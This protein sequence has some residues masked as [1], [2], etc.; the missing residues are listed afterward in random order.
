MTAVSHSEAR[1]EARVTFPDGAVYSA[2][3]GT[4]LLHYVNAAYPNGHPNRPILGGIIDNNLAELTYSVNRDLTLQPITLRDSD[5]GR[6]YRR[7]LVF[8]LITAAA[9]CFPGVKIAV[10]HSIPTGGF[11]CEPLN[12]PNFTA[13][14]LDRIRA[15]M[16]AIVAADEPFERKTIP[17]AEAVAWFTEHGD[18]DMVRL[19]RTRDKDYLTVYTMRGQVDY[20]FGY[21]VPSTG[22]LTLFDLYPMEAGF[23]LVYPRAEFVDGLHPYEP[24]HK[25]EVAFQ[26]DKAWRN[27][28]GLADIGTLNRAIEE[29][30]LREEVLIAEALHSRYLGAI[31]SQIAARHAQG[32]RLVLIAGPSSAGKTTFSKRLAIQLMAY[33]IHPFTLAMD[34]YFVDREHTPRDEFGAYDFESLGALDRA[35]MNIDLKA[36]FAGNEVQLPHFDFKLGRAVPGE[37][38]RLHDDQIIIAEGIHGL[39]P[40]LLPDIPAD[41]VFRLYVSAVTALN[42][43]RHNRVP[44]TDVRLLRRIVRD[45]AHRGYSALDTINRWESV[46]RGEKRNIFPYQE[47]AD[48]MFNSSLPYELAMLRPLAEPLLRQVEPTTWH[49]VE[50]KRLL[51]FLRWV[52][53]ADASFVPDD[54]LLREFIGGSILESYTPGKRRG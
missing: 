15:Q 41:K 18:D 2:P 39:N 14:E 6:I 30:K 25:L 43:D 38:V 19:L 36:L 12:R 23:I 20:L 28:I 51:S 50:A 8:L 35:Q 5:G 27:V 29:G 42:L 49:Y 7:S 53:P 9:E 21:M 54:S 13:A 24:S 32:L 1:S 3:I 16:S 40:E 37:V 10:E 52:R 34:N 31:A 17:L 4:P 26:Q 46:R 22:Y 47:H 45:A 33:G 48:V 44:T 11:Y